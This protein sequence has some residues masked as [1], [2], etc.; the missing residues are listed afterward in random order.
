MYGQPSP[1]PNPLQHAYQPFDASVPVDQHPSAVMGHPHYSSGFNYPFQ[2]IPDGNPMMPLQ[3][4]A[5]AAMPSAYASGGLPQVPLVEA[6]NSHAPQAAAS[7]SIPRAG[8]EECFSATESG[9]GTTDDGTARDQ[10]SPIL[11]DSIDSAADEFELSGGNRGD[12]TDLGG[13]TKDG[14]SDAPPSWSELKT[15]AGK[16]RKRLPLACIACRRKK[17]RCSGEKP[18]CKH[19]LRSRI[20]CVYKVTTRK[21]APRTDYMAMLDKRLKRM[22]ERIIKIIPKSDQ[23][24]TSTVTRAVVKPAIPG[25]MSSA[26]GQSKKRGAD[27]AFGAGLE[28]WSKSSNKTKSALD[29]EGSAT[30]DALDAEED[31]LSHEGA[32]FLPS[33]DIQEHLAEVYFDNVYGQAYH[34]L[35]KPSYMRKLKNN[36]LP[37]V[38]ILSVCAVSARFSLNPRL[39]SP[40]RQFLRGEEWAA[41]AR[42]ICNKRYESPNITILTC[43]LIM[44]LHE[45]GTCQGGRSWALGGQAFRMAFA[46]QLHKD[47]EYD[48]MSRNGQTQLSFIDREIRR[49]IMWS[50]FIMDRFISSGSERPMCI[51]EAAINIPLPVKER[52]FQLDMPVVAETLHG[53]IL[54]GHVAED[55]PDNVDAREN[56][57]VAAFMIRAIALWGRIAPYANQGGKE[58]DPF[59]L[60]SPDGTYMKL[61]TEAE[62]FQSKLTDSL[63]YTPD[64]LAL[65]N[66]HNTA[67]QF[68]LLHLIIQQNML[69]LHLVALASDADEEVHFLETARK[70]AF[71]AANRISAILKDAEGARYAITAP[72]AAYCA[73]S[74]TVL[75]IQGIV[76]GEPNLKAQSE[77]NS[78]VNIRFIRKMMKVWGMF[79]WLEEDIR[80]QYRAAMD[81][82]RSGHPTNDGKA[83]SPILQ[84]GDWFTRYPHGVADSDFMEA[85]SQRKKEKGADGVLE[86]KPELQSV[87][88]FFTTLA[89]PPQGK[90]KP[91]GP[92]PPPTKRKSVSH[93]KH[94]P[95]NSQQG[96]QPQQQ[97]QQPPPQKKQQQQQRR[98]AS[99][100]TGGQAKAPVAM[101]GTGE[102][103]SDPGSF[104]P[105]PSVSPMSMDHFG[106]AAHAQQIFYPPSTISVNMP[107]QQPNHLI[108][109]LDPQLSFG[110]YQLPTGHVPNGQNLMGG[111]QNWGA[112]TEGNESH[113]GSKL[114]N[115]GI[116]NGHAP[117]GSMASDGLNSAHVPMEDPSAAWYMQYGMQPAQMNP[118]MGIDQGNADAFN[119]MYNNGS[120]AA[121]NPLGGLRHT[122]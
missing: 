22:E 26:K 65:H 92:K 12:G 72:F 75:L 121:S 82:S 96:Q 119:N 94:S 58:R 49:R 101:N 56:I 11:G 33:K 28:A 110:G 8:L 57:G 113:Q 2:D 41:P 17:I 29:E 36:T 107:Q 47:L 90:D 104:H 63:L 5:G 15:K 80:S 3:D 111:S 117:H 93:K 48:P 30:V 39:N 19:C 84:Y 76:S 115:H 60:S 35:H 46:L 27:E 64:N 83:M 91:E 97:Q 54:P 98:R 21:A 51:E 10:I 50:C 31:Q 44:G 78:T 25:S 112:T 74:S 16:D 81:R 9:P 62:D 14:K 20:P 45:F 106:H 99:A 69:A 122:Q 108:H 37:P 23:S 40:T 34:L 89:S 53:N 118:D 86:Q 66:N 6:T 24:S 32:E 59:P 68:L 87:E 109:A 61:A 13:R 114:D 55:H 43:S 70:K 79:H 67:N 52:Y 42:E 88:E 102:P 71:A 38:L 120:M 18:A 4:H 100:A 95:S 105:A 103:I 1:H 85:A 77:A 7:S 73:F 116:I